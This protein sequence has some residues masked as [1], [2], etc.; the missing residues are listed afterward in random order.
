M[1]GQGHHFGLRFFSTTGKLI[2]L[3]V[4][5]VAL[6]LYGGA[7]LS[8]YVS[9]T[10][11]QIP[12]FLNLAYPVLLA[13][14]ILLLVISLLLRSWRSAIA[15]VLALLLSSG[16]IFTYLPLHS[17]SLS[18]DRD[19]R[20]LTYNVG[21][22]A[23]T[24]SEGTPCALSLIRESG[25]DVVCLQESLSPSQIQ[26]KGTWG[27]ELIQTYPHRIYHTDDRLLMM[28]KLPIIKSGRVDYK[29]YANGSAWYLLQLASG[30]TLL[31]INNHM[32]SYSLGSE[33]K[34]TFKSYLKDPSLDNI[35]GR[36]L[37]VKRR[38]GPSLNIRAGASN[39]VREQVRSLREQ[40][41]PSFTIVCGDFNDTPMSYCYTQIRD[42]Y[43]DAFVDAGGGLGISFNEPFYAFRIDHLFYGGPLQA[44]AAKIPSRDKCSDHN[45]LL[46]DF[47][48]LD[49]TN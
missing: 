11:S 28:S 16:Y 34:E 2:W 12:A 1:G 46:V 45:P 15:I 9:P 13:G 32:E 44:T 36:L 47:K 7:M 25:A 38:L 41:H 21:N 17:S 14:L 6:L 24:D 43:R 8:P 48:M 27:R 18:D 19:M 49:Q 37:K 20:V 10:N 5:V 30:E 29:S 39:A 33:E 26:S 35:K 42:E 4:T 23:F 40:Y 22:F 3:A 31:L